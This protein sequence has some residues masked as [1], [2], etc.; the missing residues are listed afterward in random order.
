MAFEGNY[1][2][3]HSGRKPGFF[4]IDSQGHYKVRDISR[5]SGIETTDLEIMYRTYSSEYSDD[6]EVYYFE[7]TERANALIDAIL[8]KSGQKE[9]GRLI[10]LTEKEIEFIRKAL[11]NEGSNSIHI[12]SAV[13]NKIFNKLNS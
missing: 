2:I 5:I 7:S 10:Y 3:R 1:I 11:I 4:Y 9:N 12:S 8:E 13:K 6:M